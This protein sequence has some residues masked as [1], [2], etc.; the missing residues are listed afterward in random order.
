AAEGDRPPAP[1]V[2]RELQAVA[3][4][5]VDTSGL[6]ARQQSG[7]LEQL[8]AR[9]VGAQRVAQGIEAV[10]RVA[11]LEALAGGLVQAAAAQVGAG[12][13]TAGQLAAEEAGRLAEDVVQRLPVGIGLAAA[14]LARDLHAGPAG[15]LLDRVEELE[16][17]VVHQEADGG[18]MRPAAEAVV[19]LLGRRH[20][21]AGRALVMERAARR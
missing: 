1:V 12:L 13:V 21:E 20:G 17:V 7:A 2:D 11:D 19:E 16:S 6:A 8:H 10:R 15:E 9:L 4:L 5:V 18:A 14:R 3:E